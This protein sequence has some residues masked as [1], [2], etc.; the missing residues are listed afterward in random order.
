MTAC[1]SRPELEA[2][3]ADQ[4]GGST[5]QALLTHVDTC[6]QCQQVLEELTRLEEPRTLV[7][8]NT[9]VEGL[10][11]AATMIRPGESLRA[12]DKLRRLRG[13]V[14]RGTPAGDNPPMEPEPPGDWPAVPGYEIL[15]L[16]GRG[17]MGVVYRARQIAL[18]RV[19][20]LKMV[21]GGGHAGPNE[22]ARFRLEAEAIARLHHPNIVQVH[23]VG[24]CQG[25]PFFSMEFVEGG[26]LADRLQGGPLPPAAAA[27]L[28]EV[29]ARAMHAAHLCGVVH[30]DL[31]PANILLAVASGQWSVV[32]EDKDRNASPALTTDHWP[33]TTMPKITDFGLARKLEEG[34]EL[35]ASGVVVGTP[36]YMAPEQAQGRSHTA[37]PAAD[38]YA[39]GAILYELLA[40]RPPHQG[41]TRLDTI[42][43]VLTAEPVAPRRLRPELPRDLET[44]C[45]KCLQKEPYQ[46][47]GDALE[48]AEDLRR[49]RGHEPI[50]A[51]RVRWTERLLL[52]ARR[53]PLQAAVFGLAA[54]VLVLGGLGAGAVWLWQEAEQ[55]REQL[56]GEKQ[57][58]E[59]AFQ[60]EQTAAREA[61]RARQAERQARDDLD[62][63]LY[64]RRVGLAHAEWRLNEMAQAV[65]LLEECPRE[66]RHWE[67]SYVHHL[68]HAELR[69]LRGHT[70]GVQAVAVS[71][72]GQRLASASLDKTVRVW[73]AQTGRQVQVLAGHTSAVHSVAFSPDGKRLASASLDRTV[74]LWDAETGRPDRVL[75]GHT[76]G[77]RSVAFSPD[78][79]QLASAS[80]DKTVRIW[81]TQTGRPVRVLKGHTNWVGSV[82]FSPDGQRLATGSYDTR[83]RVWDVSTGKPALVLKGHIGNVMSVA[84]SPD[85]KRLATA[86]VDRTVQ[87]WDA[88]T[89]QSLRVLRGHT[90]FV[91]SVAFSP[92]GQRLASASYDKTVR[93]WDVQTGQS[94]RVLQGHTL[95]I[96]GVAFSPDGQRLVTGSNDQTLRIWDAWIDPCTLVL[97]GPLTVSSALALSPD[98]QRLARVLQD[99]NVR[100]WDARLGREVL[101]LRGHTGPVRKLAFSPDSRRLA[102]AS[103]DK[104]VRVWDAQSGQLALVLR[105]HTRGVIQVAFSPDGLR[106][107]TA[108]VDTTVRF[109]NAHTGKPTAVVRG[110]TRPVLGM[111][112]SPDSRWLACTAVDNTVRVWDPQTGR[113]AFSPQPH[114]STVRSVAFS[115]DSRRLAMACS[116][117][118]VRVW[119]VQTGREVVVLRGRTGLLWGLAFSP[120]GE[121]LAS[122]SADSTVRIW[123][124]RTGRPVFTLRRGTNRFL[125]VAFS[126]DGRRLASVSEGGTLRLWDPQTGQEI[127]ALPAFVSSSWVGFS[128]DGRRL[129]SAHYATVQI[130]D[131]GP[132]WEP[133]APG[134]RASSPGKNQG[135]DNPSAGKERIAPGQRLEVR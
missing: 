21:L 82:A 29:L 11:E 31:K 8:R 134:R 118:T 94:V 12:E 124:L 131:A 37:G 85:G 129:A 60:R 106:L 108:S 52:W 55:A 24:E 89:G 22:L 14:P 49:F 96:R 102:S 48:L 64:L 51:R 59:L 68:C 90:D 81:D 92:D 76:S 10:A 107:S 99:F 70:G 115:P 72:D 7:G 23:E 114:A 91:D 13:L 112:F 109:W 93:I 132:G 101:V 18:D 61:G 133:V 125:A 25:S 4:L 69:E 135:A 6:R 74:R 126:P 105:G 46:R 119:E 104:T 73:D 53:R 19:V 33:L 56:A 111:V 57:Q 28:V 77:V 17:G 130:W 100:L 128:P 66:R 121:L 110:L 36:S 1:P 87:V 50:R 44:I 79:R 3:L 62:Q 113:P 42:I 120:D 75:K 38:V 117:K 5:E 78:G 39:L 98:Q 84:F 15:G 32:S 30:R 20:A 65:A 86:S 122:A 63:V 47:Y 67:W 71:R 43:Q 54:L 26:S 95:P 34:A 97:N 80:N 127:L 35:T 27:R 2:M 45:L 9:P 83:A 103:E 88:K 40:G 41:P 16:L 123:D 116:D 58:T